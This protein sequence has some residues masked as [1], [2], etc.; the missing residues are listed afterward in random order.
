[1]ETRTLT[2]ECNMEYHMVLKAVMSMFSDTSVP[3]EETLRNL[4]GL[5]DEIDLLIESLET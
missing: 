1:M 3:K 4:N 2:T 5:K